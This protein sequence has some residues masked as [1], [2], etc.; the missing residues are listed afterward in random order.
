MKARALVLAAVLLGLCAIPGCWVFEGSESGGGL[1]T[2]GPVTLSVPLELFCE[3]DRITGTVTGPDMT[4]IEASISPAN[5]TVT[6]D[7]PSGEDRELVVRAYTTD[8]PD[9]PA[10]TTAPLS[11]C[12]DAGQPVT[13]A[14]SV[15]QTNRDPVIGGVTPSGAQVTAGQ[16]VTLRADASD[17][18]GCD[19]VKTY[20]WSSDYGTITGS[21]ASATWT[22]RCPQGG[23]CQ[24]TV[25]LS[26]ADRRGGT[27]SKSFTYSIGSTN[28]APTV[29]LDAADVSGRCWTVDLTATASDPDGDALTLSWSIRS[30]PG[31][32]GGVSGAGDTTATW[33]SGCT[34]GAVDAVVEVTATDPS[35][36][37]ASATARILN[38]V[39]TVS[40][41]APWDFTAC[42]TTL[43]ATASDP[44]GDALRYSWQ[45]IAGT[46]TFVS[47]TGNPVTY[48]HGRACA[49]ESIDV[50]VTVR[51]S[52]GAVATADATHVP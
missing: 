15:K 4:A 28:A 46:G 21:G 24:A 6:L 35:G 2:G 12:V 9:T 16:A 31:T 50:R 51:D 37:S 27:D 33:D 18:D 17:P 20:R 41:S 47:A 44:D 25:N 45:V 26:V 14:L 40:V 23:A 3:A 39:P 52:H 43:T 38:R 30:G 5:A 42:M 48:D 36:E 1:C 29:S 22:P 34:T 32:L 13:V 8:A 7:I 10:L 19:A 49:P 11:F